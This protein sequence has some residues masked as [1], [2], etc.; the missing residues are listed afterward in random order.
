MP[1]TS[2]RVM[3]TVACLL[4]WSPVFAA[5]RDE[6]GSRSAR[7]LHVVRG[8]EFVVDEAI[9]TEQLDELAENAAAVQQ[10][11]VEEL[12]VPPIEGPVRI[13]LFAHQKDFSRYVL[14]NIPSVN[15]SE[16]L[17]RHGIFLLRQG[18][19]YVFL[20]KGD[21]LVRSLRHEC[22]HVVL[23]V[24]HPGLPIWMDEGLAQCYEASDGSHWSDRAARVLSKDVMR[25]APP[26]AESLT[27]LRSM[28]QL[29]TR[30]Y[31]G[32]W[33][34]LHHLLED[35]DAGRPALRAYLAALMDGNEKPTLA[36]RI[37][38][39]NRAA[40]ATRTGGSAER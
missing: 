27:K 21:D 11:L 30:E 29:G 23:N 22:V 26:T 37:P 10:Q 40:F 4:L 25:R 34:N 39:L 36:V 1:Q 6:T 28:S 12:A 3:T 9:S 7:Q 5:E 16:T 8:V 17:G 18:R 35:E 24:S 38:P 13:Y 20:V 31:A 33:A 14:E 15:R 32:C 19:P 2:R